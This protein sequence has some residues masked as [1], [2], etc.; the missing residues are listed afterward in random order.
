MRRLR[1]QR[2]E[3]ELPADLQKLIRPLP[4]SFSHGQ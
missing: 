2:A 3:F 4:R 1:D